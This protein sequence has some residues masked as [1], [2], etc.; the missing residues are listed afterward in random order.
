MSSNLP[1][2]SSCDASQV[3][4]PLVHRAEYA[5]ILLKEISQTQDSIATAQKQE[6]KRQVL[7]GQRPALPAAGKS[8]NPNYMAIL[9]EAFSKA[10]DAMAN[11][12]KEQTKAYAGLQQLDLTMSQSVLR[13]TNLSIAK[14]ESEIKITA[15]IAAYQAKTAKFNE[16]L[17]EV[18]KWSGII[19]V[20]AVII[21]TVASAVFDGGLS[22]AFVPEEIS[23]L[24]GEGGAEAA[25]DGAED[26]VA[27]DTFSSSSDAAEAGE[28]AEGAEGAASESNAAEASEESEQAETAS[29]QTKATV[30]KVG[31]ENAKSIARLKWVGKKVGHILLGGLF[32]APMLAKGVQGI[33][34]S[35]MQNAAADAE[36][37][38]G[39]ALATLK[40]NQQ[41]FEFFQQLVERSGGVLEASTNNA[42]QVEETFSNVINSY[43]QISYGLASAA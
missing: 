42:S 15:Q 20:S 25:A 35:E 29:S 1:N 9:A 32:G 6:K 36:K 17:G 24:F 41:Y 22:L 3:L 5:H 38:V 4:L 18:V 34:T 37:S 27:M 19:F 33:K 40:E 21:G 26:G 11:G 31:N 43:K 30:E 13:S 39:T 7:V 14:Q 28:A 12:T 23:A 8:K 16:T 2:T 10:Y